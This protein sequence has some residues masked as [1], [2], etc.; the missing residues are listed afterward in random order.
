MIILLKGRVAVLF[1]YILFNITNNK[2]MSTVLVYLAAVGFLISIFPVHVFNYIYLN[3]ENRY[4]SVN[5]GIYKLR[6]FN[7]NTVEDKPYEMQVNGK[8][9]KIDAKKFKLSVIYK[10]FNCLCLYKIV[11]LADYG[12]GKEHNAYVALAQNAFSTMIYK[13]IQINGNYCKLRNYT[14][15]NEEHSEIRYYAK[16]VTIINGIVIAKILLIILMEKLHERKA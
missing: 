6:F 8:N 13:F 16:A 10:I 9:K 4:A 14:I 7:A 12:M 1:L 11:Q 5:A 15:L 3:T 2:R